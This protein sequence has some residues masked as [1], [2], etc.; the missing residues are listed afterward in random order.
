MVEAIII[1]KPTVCSKY[2]KP[3]LK[4]PKK[5]PRIAKGR[6]KRRY[7][8]ARTSKWVMYGISAFNLFMGSRA[9][10]FAID[11]SYVEHYG[12][13]AIINPILMYGAS[14]IT[15]AFARHFAKEQKKL[16]GVIEGFKSNNKYIEERVSV[17][18]NEYDNGK[19]IEIHPL[20]NYQELSDRV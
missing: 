13:I 16:K 5:I 19:V 1:R 17:F 15:F 9:L 8:A 11:P 3:L 14:L 20:E 4:R 6:T 10:Y 18:D 12:S 7:K 2:K